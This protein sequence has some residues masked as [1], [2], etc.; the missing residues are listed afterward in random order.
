MVVVCLRVMCDGLGQWV[1]MK[2]SSPGLGASDITR[3][4]VGMGVIRA[5]RE[6]VRAVGGVG[7][8]CGVFAWSLAGP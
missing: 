5:K 2:R 6:V 8:H 1:A 7:M 3:G 4:G